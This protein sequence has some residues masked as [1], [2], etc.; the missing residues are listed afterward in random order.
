M[1]WLLRKSFSFCHFSR[2]QSLSV[3]WDKLGS[4]NS[5]H[6]FHDWAP[7][8]C[9]THY[10]KWYWFFS[11]VW[12]AFLSTIFFT[13]KVCPLDDI[14]MDS[15]NNLD[16]FHDWL[17]KLILHCDTQHWSSSF[18]RKTI[19]SFFLSIKIHLSNGTNM[20]SHNNLHSFRDWHC[21]HVPLSKIHDTDAL[22]LED[23]PFFLPF[24]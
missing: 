15:H 4:R 17:H 2:S 6:S 18:T 3:K 24:S 20:A 7:K 16:H 23:M 14:D 1:L 12:K 19:S 13:V 9:S 8:T 5:H 11:F 10:N 22:E 21:K